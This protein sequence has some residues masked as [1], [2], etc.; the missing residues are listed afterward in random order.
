MMGAVFTLEGMVRGTVGAVRGRAT[1]TWRDQRE[2]KCRSMARANLDL[3][4]SPS[5]PFFV[6]RDRMTR[7]AAR[8]V[9][10]ETIVATARAARQRHRLTQADVAERVEIASEVYG[11]LER[12]RR[13]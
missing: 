13:G 5:C 1:H 9:L 2:E 4:G 10:A 11:R 8:D 12:L 7:M 3:F 6:K